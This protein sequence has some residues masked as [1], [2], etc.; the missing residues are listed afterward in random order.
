MFLA[1]SCAE[2]VSSNLKSTLVSV[3][4]TLSSSSVPPQAC[5][6]FSSS[7]VSPRDKNLPKN[8]R[9]LSDV[10]VNSAERV[11][12]KRIAVPS[13]KTPFF[14]KFR[15]SPVAAQS[16]TKQNSA[17]GATVATSSTKAVATSIPLSERKEKI[18][19]VL[20]L[21]THMYLKKNKKVDQVQHFLVQ[22]KF[23]NKGQTTPK[24]TFLV[25]LL[26]LK[27]K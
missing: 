25:S 18:A 20:Q 10:R 6:I 13:T 15:T 19:Q 9:I 14:L 4:G 21:L 8:P 16:T 27:L 24:T 7:S 3:A 23:Q 11:P 26:L 2:N 17:S 22:L 5:A 12:I 1:K